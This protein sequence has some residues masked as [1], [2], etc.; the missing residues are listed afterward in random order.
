MPRP[1]LHTLVIADDIDGW[2]RA[3]FV[4]ER[5]ADREGEIWVGSIRFTMTGRPP[6]HAESGS[7][8][9]GIVAWEFD[10][11]DAIDDGGI[12][13]IPTARYVA[14]PTERQ[15]SEV[16]RA[17]HPNGASR[18]DHVVMM[19]PDLDRTVGA[20]ERHGFEAR[21][22]RVIPG[23]EPPRQQV[24]FWAGETIIELVAPVTATGDDP[25]R[26]WG[27][28]ITT[29]DIDSAATRL[30]EH[31]SS[32]KPAVQAGRRIATVRTADLD[33]STAIA[34]MSP[35]TVDDINSDDRRA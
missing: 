13:G 35:H 12:D 18:L 25:A 29:D 17:W 8:Q 20:L 26:L 6:D 1:A 10:E 23:S 11:I 28:A 5:T 3:G 4:V 31:M 34:L 19:S 24:F 21:R 16:T 33:I 15:A 22:T 9:R 30:G 14:D 7:P 27:L 2:E 32:P